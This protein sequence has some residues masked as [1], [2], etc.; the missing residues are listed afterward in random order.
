[1]TPETETDSPAT[2]SNDRDSSDATI[3]CATE[4]C[5]S[6]SSNGVQGG[7]NDHPGTDVHSF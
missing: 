7:K 6:T 1:M 5:E 2:G 3:T 4:T